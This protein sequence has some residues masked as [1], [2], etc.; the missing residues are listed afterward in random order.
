MK[1]FT[2]AVM[3]FTVF[4]AVMA[5]SEYNALCQTRRLAVIEARMDKASSL[6]WELK[7]KLEFPNFPPKVGIKMTNKTS[8]K[9]ATKG[10]VLICK[11]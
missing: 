3:I 10:M 5:I 2:I 4:S 8:M 11:K 9:Y 1:K 6:M 7:T